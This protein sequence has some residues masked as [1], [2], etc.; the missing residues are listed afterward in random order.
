MPGLMSAIVE[1]E[2]ATKSGLSVSVSFSSL[3][4]RLLMT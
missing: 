1:G 2:M 3:P 4:S